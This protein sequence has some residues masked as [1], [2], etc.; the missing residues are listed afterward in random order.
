MLLAFAL[1]VCVLFVTQ[2]KIFYA[3]KPETSTRIEADAPVD[4]INDSNV[5]SNVRSCPS[6]YNGVTDENQM[7][8]CEAGVN[9]KHS[10]ICTGTRTSKDAI[11]YVVQK[12]HSTYGS[13]H[14]SWSLFQKSLHL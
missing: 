3:N 14:S 12:K 11:M 13:G 2:L 1:T 7:T 6:K 4:S 10:F 5:D 9:C 8:L